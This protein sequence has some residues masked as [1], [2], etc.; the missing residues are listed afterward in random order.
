M[1]LQVHDE[2]IFDVPVHEIE[3]MKAL[4]K[5]GMEGAMELPNGVPVLAEAGSG[6]NWLE[7]H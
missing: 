6:M 1:V 7:A 3:Q 2:L 5:Q 4:I